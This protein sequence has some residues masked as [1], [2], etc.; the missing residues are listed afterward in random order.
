MLEL[1]AE[2][3]LSL[4]RC[5]GQQPG[6][7]SAALAEHITLQGAPGEDDKY[8]ASLKIEGRRNPMAGP[9]G[10]RGYRLAFLLT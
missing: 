5:R 1:G 9:P 8:G 10:L 4:I 3:Q 2:S 7:S 6:V